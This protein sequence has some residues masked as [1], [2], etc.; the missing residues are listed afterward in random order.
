MQTSDSSSGDRKVRNELRE[1]GT[2]AL[3]FCFPKPNELVCNFS[4][5][6]RVDY[7]GL[8][9]GRSLE[10]RDPAAQ[11]QGAAQGSTDVVPTAMVQSSSQET[12]SNRFE[13]SNHLFRSPG[14][15]P[16]AAA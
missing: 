4:L 2:G 9:V 7:P 10:K 8:E 6:H 5:E 13:R 3:S 12:A 16:V 11:G 14:P 15:E 1:V